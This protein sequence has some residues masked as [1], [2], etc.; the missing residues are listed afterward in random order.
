MLKNFYFI[1]VLT[2]SFAWGL[3]NSDWEGAFELDDGTVI[4]RLRGSIEKIEN[5]HEHDTPTT[6]TF[7]N[8]AIL[9]LDM[10]KETFCKTLNE[11]CRIVGV[12]PPTLADTITTASDP[13]LFGASSLPSSPRL[14]NLEGK[15]FTEEE[16]DLLAPTLGASERLKTF[17]GERTQVKPTS[18]PE[19]PDKIST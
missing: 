17:W 19:S 6:H 1:S 3:D 13:N 16:P 14:V 7:V 12:M 4:I 5:G 15:S 8:A 9:T 18:E 11:A 2:V 10:D